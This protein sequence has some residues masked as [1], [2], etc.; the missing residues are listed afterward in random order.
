MTFP[1]TSH[2]PGLSIYHKTRDESSSVVLCRIKRLGCN[3]N[4]LCHRG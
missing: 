2:V 1:A 3:S 4:D